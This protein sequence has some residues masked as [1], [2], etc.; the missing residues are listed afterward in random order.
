ME[1]KIKKLREGAIIPCKA[2]AG[3]AAYD[4]YI[5]QDYT[6]KQGRQVIPLGFAI[7]MPYGLEAKIEP[8]SGFASKGMEAAD[9]IRHDCDVISGKIDS[10]YRG[11]CGVIVNNRSCEFRLQA[12]AR[13]AQMTI[14]WVEDAE[15]TPAQELSDTDRGEGGFGHSG[16]H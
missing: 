4:V 13:V 16:V 11:E 12:G 14:Y 5:P 6:V 2:T 1:I 10:D 15:F 9:R 7:E 3:S 8:R